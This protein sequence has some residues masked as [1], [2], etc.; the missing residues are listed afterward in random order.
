[1]TQ[2][3]PPKHLSGR[4]ESTYPHKTFST[5]CS[6][7]TD[8]SPN[9]EAAQTCDGWVDKHILTYLVTEVLSKTEESD[10]AA[11]NMEEFKFFFL[12]KKR[13]K[14]KGTHVR[15]LL[16]KS[17][18]CNHEQEQN[19]AV[20]AWDV[21]WDYDALEE[22]LWDDGNV[23]YLDY[24]DAR[25]CL[26]SSKCILINVCVIL[27]MCWKARRKYSWCIFTRESLIL[28]ESCQQALSGF[29]SENSCR[30]GLS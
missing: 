26:K 9:L 14:H 25:I 22:T 18:N 10:T 1:M 29:G 23:L 20:I 16:Q 28:R 3:S 15:L 24:D 27:C 5:M 6:N 12:N 7:V 19:M 8:D 4:E 17:R 30:P 21:S 13:Y 2:Q 11:N